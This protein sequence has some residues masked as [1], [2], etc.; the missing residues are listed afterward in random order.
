[1]NDTVE[2][3]WAELKTRGTN[4]CPRFQRSIQNLRQITP[5]TLRSTPKK[6]QSEETII[7]PSDKCN[8]QHRLRDEIYCDKSVRFH[9]IIENIVETRYLRQEIFHSV[10]HNVD[11][12]CMPESNVE[13]NKKYK[14]NTGTFSPS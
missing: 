10:D 14:Y 2:N 1:M 9:W 13:P 12:D 8:V 11:A 5:E 6:I 7:L 4:S 3:L